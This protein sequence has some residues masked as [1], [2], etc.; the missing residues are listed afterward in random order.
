GGARRG[1]DDP[2][3]GARLQAQA[4]RART[5]PRGAGPK[6][7]R[8]RLAVGV[9]LFALGPGCVFAPVTNHIITGT[10]GPAFQ[11]PVQVLLD[12]TPVPPSFRE[13]AILQARGVGY[14]ANLRS[15]VDAMRLNAAALG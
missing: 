12:G 2:N 5:R 8:P 13:I 11:G 4:R 1:G 9:L 10:P 6:M 14:N 15:L 7:I 3:A